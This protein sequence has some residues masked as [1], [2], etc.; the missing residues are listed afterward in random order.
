MAEQDGHWVMGVIGSI[1]YY[2]NKFGNRQLATSNLSLVNCNPFLFGFVRLCVYRTTE[3]TNN[4]C[5]RAFGE[6]VR[7]Q[8]LLQALN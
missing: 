2:T 4:S 5:V 7:Y 8:R 1:G 6:T 3:Q